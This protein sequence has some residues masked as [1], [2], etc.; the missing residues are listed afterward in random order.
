MACQGGYERCSACYGNGAQGKSDPF[1]DSFKYNPSPGSAGSS[2]VIS[3]MTDREYL[4]KHHWWYKL[5]PN[6]R[7]IF[8]PTLIALFLFFDPFGLIPRILNYLL[9]GL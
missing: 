8:F 9:L 3:T 6:Q 2:P 4:E 1:W 5:T 7:K